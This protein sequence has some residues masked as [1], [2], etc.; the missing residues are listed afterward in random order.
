MDLNRPI[1]RSKLWLAD[2]RKEVVLFIIFFLVSIISFSLG[3][4]AAG[5]SSR[6][7]III[8]DNSAPI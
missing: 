4:L 6:A 8:E 1:A 2:N 7:P 3:Y 5:E